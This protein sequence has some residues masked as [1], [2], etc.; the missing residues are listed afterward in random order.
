MSVVISMRERTPS[1][2]IFFVFLPPFSVLCEVGARINFF[3]VSV[4]RLLPQVR[5]FC[6]FGELPFSKHVFLV[7]VV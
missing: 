1:M 5:D 4:C 3:A 6:C 7:E 2:L